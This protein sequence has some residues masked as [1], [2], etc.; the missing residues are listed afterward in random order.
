MYVEV[1]MTEGHEVL[2][3]W[4]KGKSIRSIS[5]QT[6]MARRTVKRYIKAA[7]EFGLKQG[8]GESQITQEMVDHVFSQIRVGRHEAQKGEKWAYCEGHKEILQGWLGQVIGVKKM[9]TLLHRHTGVEVPYSTLLR[10]LKQELGY[11]KSK[12]K[13]TVRVADSEP[14]E[15]LEVDFGYLG[16]LTDKDTG[17]SRKVWALVFTAGYSRHMYVWLTYRQRV[18][19]VIEGMEHAHQFFGGVFK[20]LLPDNMKTVVQKADRKNPRLNQVF[21][22]YSQARGF[23]ID[24][25]RVRSPKDKP[26]VER[27]VQYVQGSFFAGEE[28]SSLADAQDRVEQWLLNEAGLRDHGTTHR[29]PLRVFE[30]E[31]KPVLLPWDGKYYD[32][33]E[34]KDVLVH[35]D[36]HITINRAYY[37]VPIE[38]VGHRVHVRV[39][40]SQVKIYYHGQLV[41][42][43]PRVEKGKFSTNRTHYPEHKRIYACRDIKALQK[44]ADETGVNIGR[45]VSKL[46]GQPEKWRMMKLIYHVL[47]LLDIYDAKAVDKACLALL[48]IGLFDP[49]RL[50][51]ILKAGID[52]Q[53]LLAMSKAPDKTTKKEQ[54]PLDTYARPI[55]DFETHKSVGVSSGRCV[56]GVEHKNSTNNKHK[57]HKGD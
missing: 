25:A 38:H 5:R 43:H 7:Q 28:F 15:Y 47:R 22:E 31:E 40:S 46:A 26:K 39:D 21:L 19:D 10:Y 41:T 57:K 27:S 49:Y 53:A 6:G 14:G 52:E 48:E 34:F 1:R 11:K 54:K 44:Q 33:P 12:D 4:E 30:E 16:K 37:S 24:P 32:V 9:V 23:S 55:S 8:E 50:E 45:F 18:Q 42:T 13:A 56:G 20:V 35:R 2:R 17:K 29:Q 3:Q 36:Q 51:N